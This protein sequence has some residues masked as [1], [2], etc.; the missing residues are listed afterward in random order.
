M[1]EVAKMIDALDNL[2][3]KT[4]LSII[5]SGGLRR[6]ELL[7]LKIAAVNSKRMLKQI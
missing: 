4:M 3:H 2:K 1:E 5:Y 6:S 7:N